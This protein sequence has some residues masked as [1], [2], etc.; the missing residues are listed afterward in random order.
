MLLHPSIQEKVHAEIDK[1][2]GS[3]RPPT[4]EDQKDMPYFSAAVLETLR[5]N[6]VA[7][8]GVPHAPLK[9]DV[10]NGYFIP[11]DT[12]VV[13]NEWGISRNPRYYTN[14]SNFD[15]ERYLKPVPELDPREFTFG[16]G[17]RACPGVELGYRIVWIMAATVLWAFRLEREQ[18]DNTPLNTDSERF[19]IWML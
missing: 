18:G 1:V 14:P 8:D 2:V 11:K 16:F 3:G 15:P 7:A 17:R 5:W 4:L 6:P 13:V 12:T 10:Y 9:D 19:R